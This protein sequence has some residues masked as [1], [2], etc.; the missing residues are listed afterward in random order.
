MFLSNSLNFILNKIHARR[1]FTDEYVA[2]LT[3]HKYFKQISN[4]KS[5]GTLRM[6]YEPKTDEHSALYKSIYEGLKEYQPQLHDAVHGFRSGYSNVTNAA[7]HLSANHLFNIDIENFYAQINDIDVLAVFLEL[8]ANTEVATYLSKLCTIDGVLPQGLNTSP[9]IANHH[10][11]SLDNALSEY[12]FE[13]DIT[14]TRYVDDM[15][16]S[17]K[18]Q[19]E[20]SEICDIVESFGLPLAQTKRK[21]QKR[22][23]NQYVTGLTI[24]DDERPRIGKKYKRRIR[25]ELHVIR[26]VGIANFIKRLHEMP[27]QPQDEAEAEKW[28]KIL[29]ELA[30]KKLSQLKG[31]LDYINGVE[32]LVA[33]KMYPIYEEIIADRKKNIKNP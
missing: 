12:A 30:D 1:E 11:N 3:Q 22:G 28:N 21:Y 17:S 19:I 14:Y 8:G 29:D 6:I 24:F 2:S 10:L 32:P 16:F 4:R 13:Q 20:A 9:D 31:R 18:S 23:A 7:Q 33:Q 15:S 5:D 26:R 27:D 25:L